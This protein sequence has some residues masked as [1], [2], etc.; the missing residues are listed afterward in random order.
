M[1]QILL[2]EKDMVFVVLLYFHGHMN[3]HMKGPV[4]EN[5][6]GFIWNVGVKDLSSKR[7]SELVAKSLNDA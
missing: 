5:L 4:K 6:D 7:Y 2:T 3:G 1:K